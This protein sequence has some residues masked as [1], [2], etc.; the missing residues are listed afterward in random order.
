MVTLTR[1]IRFS[2]TRT[3]DRHAALATPRGNTQAGWPSMDTIAGSAWDATIEVRGIPNPST[4]YLI[5]IDRIDHEVRTRSIPRLLEAHAAGECTAAFVARTILETAGPGI[6][7]GIHAVEVGVEP[8]T[9]W[10]VESGDMSMIR[11]QR[12]YEFSASHRLHLPE[13]DDAEN[14]ALFGKCS[15]PNGHG[16]NYEVEVRIATSGVGPPL[17]ILAV[18]AVVDTVLIDRFD[19][20]HLNLDLDDF[21]DSVASVENITSRC[22]ELLRGPISAL[23]ADSELHSVKVWE[24]PRTACT[25]LA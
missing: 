23:R 15:N 5:G 2:L 14:E 16:H 22:V 8:K 12:R 3:F 7:H 18:D 19:H 21:K 20:K 11:V 6:V 17:S 9:R 25:V 13:L 10:R 4:G 24:T 1:N